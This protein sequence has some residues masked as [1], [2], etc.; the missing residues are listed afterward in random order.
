MKIRH[1][2][3]FNLCDEILDLGLDEAQELTERSELRVNLDQAKI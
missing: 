1:H 2:S 3:D